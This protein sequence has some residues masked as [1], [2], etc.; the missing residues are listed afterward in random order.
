LIWK[1][2]FNQR[3][4]QVA[5]F[6][7]IQIG[8]VFTYLVWEYLYSKNIADFEKP[9]DFQN[10]SQIILFLSAIVFV[11]IFESYRAYNFQ[12]LSNLTSEY[13]LAFKV[14]FFG[15]IINGFA[16]YIF[17][18]QTILPL[19]IIFLNY[20]IISLFL[21]IEKTV[22]YYV[23]REVRKKYHK[24][25]I[26]VIGTGKDVRKFIKSLVRREYVGVQLIGLVSYSKDDIGKKI[27]NHKVIGKSEDIEDIIRQ[28]NPEEII[29]SAQND[30]SDRMQNLILKCSQ[31][32]VQI[33]VILD[34]D[35]TMTKNTR[36]D[37]IDDIN[38]IS[39]YPYYK[40]SLDIVIKRLMD[41][42]LSIIGLVLL[43][44]ILLTTYL[45]IFIKDGF[46]ILY[47]WQ[48]MGYNRRPIRS[49]KFRTM[50]KNADELKKELL[51]EN[52]MK[53][54]MFKMY[55]DP[56]I[57]PFGYF[58]R[59]YSIDELPQL[60]SVLK[61]DLSLVGPR[62]PLRYE[63]DEFE[64]WQMRKLSVKPGLTC[65]WQINGRNDIN[66]FDDWVRLDLEYIDNW[67]ILLDL[68]IL[69]KT[70][71]IVFKGSGK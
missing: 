70:I 40:S 49:W 52:E 26:I 39:F 36:M 21:I 44:P 3:I 30:T 27:L 56:R 42:V 60:F 5:D 65:L 33:R 59:K 8:Y 67:S 9:Y 34:L 18:S 29:I 43:S 2:K 53:G 45:M 16:F 22:M 7:T 50:V 14:T 19:N 13:R 25:R 4:A 46:P 71:I 24:R 66:D 11:I 17:D 68:K 51:Q 38:F 31:S 54:P 10:S 41:I 37:N 62:P 57:L 12:M 58:L 63:F 15:L 64:L 28:F 55:K 1:S 48:V 61:G 32:G 69:F 20:V 23:A 35:K 6:V 47:R